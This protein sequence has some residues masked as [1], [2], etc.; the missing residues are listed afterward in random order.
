M[1]PTKK[2]EGA[3]TE[4]AGERQHLMKEGAKRKRGR[5]MHGGQAA[6]SGAFVLLAKGLSSSRGK[7]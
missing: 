7:R 1:R 5:K 3:A 6:P 4:G 2:K